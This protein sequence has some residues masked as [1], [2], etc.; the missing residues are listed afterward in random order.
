MCRTVKSVWEKLKK[1]KL[2]CKEIEDHNNHRDSDFRQGDSHNLVR[3]LGL[4]DN[5]GNNR[6]QKFQEKN[7]PG[8]LKGGCK[9]FRSKV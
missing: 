3:N 6:T 1:F 9:Y 4:C 8:W 2:G 5:A 7:V